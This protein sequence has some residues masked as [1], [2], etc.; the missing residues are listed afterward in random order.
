MKLRRYLLCAM[1]MLGFDVS[2]AISHG[3][4]PRVERNGVNYTLFEHTATGA[5]VEFVEN[6]GICETTIGVNQYS[7]YLNVGIDMNMWFW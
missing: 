5:R 7:G 6:S 3:G 2:L 4:Q 1:L